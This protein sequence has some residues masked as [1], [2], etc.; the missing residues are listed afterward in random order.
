MRWTRL[1]ALPTMLL[2]TACNPE[3]SEVVVKIVCPRIN[4]YDAA[5]QDKALAELQALPKDSALRLFVGDYKQLR[6]Q[7]RVCRARAGAAK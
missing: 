1:L 2:L 4:E 3:N 7:I 6:D 5:T